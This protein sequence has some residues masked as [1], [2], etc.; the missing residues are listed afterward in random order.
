[1]TRTEQQIKS[2]WHDSNEIVVSIL[3]TTFNH[4]RYIRDAI[5]G[6]LAQE[7]SY[8]F[9]IIIH[10]DASTD[11]TLSVV[12]SFA[13][14][15]PSLIK[16]VAQKENQYSQGKKVSLIAYG[17]SRG[18]Y[19]ALCEGDD[20]W[21]DTHKLQIQIDEMLRYP[22]CDIS[23]HPARLID[24]SGVNLPK[25][26]CQHADTTLVI[27]TR[28]VILGG[29]GYMPTASLI[30]HRRV[31]ERLPHWFNQVPF[32]DYFIQCFGAFNA[33]A[34]YVNH[35]MSVYRINVP[36][37]WSVRNSHQ[38][39]LREDVILKIV[40]FSPLLDASSGHQFTHVFHLCTARHF[41][42]L[43]YRNARNFRVLKAWVYA[44]KSMIY[45]AKACGMLITK[46][47]SHG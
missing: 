32:G 45:Y 35:T 19:I 25:E 24:A 14:M 7:T 44:M 41:L 6:F 29:G 30:L 38:N 21:T 9:E 43:S 28:S 27:P 2:T 13:N 23:F 26:A 8:P 34:L 18:K 11:G 31:F 17:Y 42:S 33:G 1:M 39:K 3:C 37:S 12:Q 36:E 22:A 20:Y 15:Y 16:V 5:T 4:E 40:E 46:R 10:D 47:D